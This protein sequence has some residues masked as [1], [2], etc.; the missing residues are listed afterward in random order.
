MSS[1]AHSHRRNNTP[2]WSH[3]RSVRDDA[4]VYNQASCQ[5]S[6]T[7][8]HLICQVGSCAKINPLRVYCSSFCLCNEITQIGLRTKIIHDCLRS[9]NVRLYLE[10]KSE[11]SAARRALKSIEA[12]PLTGIPNISRSDVSLPTLSKSL[13]S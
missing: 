11:K 7:H 12:F 1:R 2:S 13:K 3:C 10:V 5:H 9:A 4:L 6:S 8:H